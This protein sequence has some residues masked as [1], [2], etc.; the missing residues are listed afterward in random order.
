MPSRSRSPAPLGAFQTPNSVQ[1]CAVGAQNLRRHPPKPPGKAAASLRT[2]SAKICIYIIRGK[3]SRW[4]KRFAAPRQA[5]PRTSTRLVTHKR[6]ERGAESP[7]MAV[8]AATAA[9]AATQSHPAS[10]LPN[11]TQGQGAIP[12]R[13]NKT[14]H[15]PQRR[16]RACDPILTRHKSAPRSRSPAQQHR[17][18]Q[19][20]FGTLFEGL[21]EGGRRL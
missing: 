19:L 12:Q 13:T 20:S 2:I 16:S 4:G 7:V 15:L 3:S 11:R 14:P 17:G 21:R 5:T 8:V 9:G 1:H 6:G 10:T 18:T